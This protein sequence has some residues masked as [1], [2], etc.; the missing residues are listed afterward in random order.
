MISRINLTKEATKIT[1]ALIHQLRLRPNI[2]SRN[3]LLYSIGK[4]DRYNKK[5]RIKCD[6]KELNIQVLIGDNAEIYFML[7]KQAYGLE[8]KKINIKHLIAFHIEKGLKDEK[9]I[10][11]IKGKV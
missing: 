1:A 6:G 3:A 7:I 9:F 2:T 11:T 8:I 4:G 10:N 5:T